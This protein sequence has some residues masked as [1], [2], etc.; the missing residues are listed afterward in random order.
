VPA[1]DTLPAVPQNLIFM[2]K[3]FGSGVTY[4]QKIARDLKKLGAPMTGNF[5]DF[6]C[7]WGRLAYGLLTNDFEGEYVGIDILENRVE[8]L[9]ENISPHFPRYRFLHSP[10]KNDRYR[11]NGEDRQIHIKD[12]V[13]DTTFQNVCM[14]SV[15]THMW[16]NDFQHYLSSVAEVLAD[17]G[18]FVF[19]CFALDPF[20]KHY[21]EKAGGSFTMRHRHDENCRYE[22]TDDPLFAI[23]YEYD[24]IVAMMQKAG[25]ALVSLTTGKWSGR[26]AVEFQD[27]IVAKKA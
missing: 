27:W 4:G 6:G 1:I 21:I 18:V 22:S 16:A 3:D 17:D 7:G 26:P 11:K 9:S 23:S 13:G 19:T 8:W 15:F 14:T 5:L 12:M 10:S 2:D 25:L 20:S 24:L